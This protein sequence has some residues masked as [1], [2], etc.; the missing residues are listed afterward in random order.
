VSTI[1]PSLAEKFAEHVPFHRPRPEL[2]R[3]AADRGS[4]PPDFGTLEMIVR[5]PTVEEREVL[6]E[7]LLDTTHG[8]VGD[9]WEARTGGDPDDH[10]LLCQITVMN[11]RVL[12]TVAG[13]RERW[14]L[15]GDQLI[16]DLDL[17]IDNLPPGSRLQ[18]G[19]AVLEVSSPPHTGCSKFAGRFGT[20]ALTW[21][22]TPE[23]RQQRRRGMNTRVVRSGAV[24]P[25]DV[26]KR[27]A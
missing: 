8:L 27:L 5:R 25:G 21:T 12:A 22:N 18:V 17:S 16:V 3:I 13:E 2:E 10:D 15:A 24:Q 14:R 7:G 11:S 20:D 4:S 9:S 26:V 1:K 6:S 19:E 23:G